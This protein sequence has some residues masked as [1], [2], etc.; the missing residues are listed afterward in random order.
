M[1]NLFLI[2]LSLIF[3]A[4]FHNEVAAL[5]RIGI[6]SGDKKPDI[7]VESFK[8]KS[9]GAV[10][11]AVFSEVTLKN[12]DD[13]DF[14]SVTLKARFYLF[15][16]KPAGSARG[17]IKKGLKAG[18]VKTFSN[19]RLGIMNF[20]MDRVE[21]EVAGAVEAEGS[22]PG[23]PLLVKSWNWEAGTQGVGAGI[24]EKITVENPSSTPYGRVKFLI[25]QRETGGDRV[26]SSSARM[27][28]IAEA[29]TETVYENINPGFLHPSAKEIEVK[30]ISAEP[31]SRKRAA[32]MKVE[33]NTPEE[34]YAA[35]R[36]SAVPGY[37]IEIEK[38][39]W[40]SGMAGSDGTIKFLRLKNRSLL[41]YREV[42]MTVEFLS[43]KG[44]ARISNDF[45]IKNPPPPGETRDYRNLSVGLM[46]VSPDKK[47]VKIRVKGGSPAPHEK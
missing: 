31:V 39:E 35:D 44:G 21:L 45:R 30:I 18:E 24:I 26:G 11:K 40:G 8:W 46:S 33:K 3:F 17:R 12:N 6:F 9:G 14:S 15:N 1:K 25:I 22:K 37:D 47:S 13:K 41:S 34:N 19:V 29:G 28:K 2:T 38:F 42:T 43:G 7:S 27:N 20:N 32:L 16:G 36:E 10:R 4:F 23:H 5:P